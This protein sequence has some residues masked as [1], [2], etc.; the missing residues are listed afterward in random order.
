M[1]KSDRS[2]LLVTTGSGDHGLGP[3]TD[4]VNS[5]DHVTSDQA[6]LTRNMSHISH[7]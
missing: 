2:S 6:P 5:G 1:A 3:G 4:H 7:Q